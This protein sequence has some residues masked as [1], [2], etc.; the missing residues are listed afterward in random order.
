MKPVTSTTAT[1][2][3]LVNLKKALDAGTITPDEYD[4][5]RARI[6]KGN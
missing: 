3:Q 2:Q 1:G 4:K 5:E 6:L